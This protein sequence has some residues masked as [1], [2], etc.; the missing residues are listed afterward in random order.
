M[1]NNPFSNVNSI[2]IE[3]E[4]VS[5]G[6]VSGIDAVGSGI[7]ATVS[8]GKATFTVAAIGGTIDAE[9]DGVSVGSP[10]TLN[11]IGNGVKPPSMTGST[12][13][14]TFPRL[15]VKEI[16]VA[17]SFT[18]DA[19]LGQYNDI[20][21]ALT[22]ADAIVSGDATSYVIVK[23]LAGLHPVTSV[24]N[25]NHQVVLQFETGA[26]LNLSGFSGSTLIS[27][28][29]TNFIRNL[30]VG[31]AVGVG[32]PGAGFHW[33]DVEDT[34][35]A[36]LPATFI[37]NC[38]LWDG[39][40]GTQIGIDVKHG[41]TNKVTCFV[42]GGVWTLTSTA[43]LVKATGN[44]EIY[45]NK[46]AELLCNGSPCLDTNDSGASGPGVSVTNAV[47]NR[48]DAGDIITKSTNASVVG[49]GFYNAILDISKCAYRRVD[50]LDRMINAGQIYQEELV[51]GSPTD[52]DDY[53]IEAA[54]SILA[55][56]QDRHNSGGADAL[57]L[58]DLASPDDNT[59]L[60]VSTSAHG[61]TPKAPNDTDKFL[62]GDA[63][64]AVPLLGVTINA[65]TGTT[66]SL[67]NSDKG[68]LV[69]L[70]NASAIT[71]TVP[72]GLDSDFSCVIMQKG[73]GQVTISASGTTV[74]NADSFTK[75][76]KQYCY[77][78]VTHLGSNVYVTDGRLV[79]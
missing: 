64:W 63:T 69:T 2:E 32:A 59:D 48:V 76:E 9:D 36:Q 40:G 68:K 71:L 6:S 18:D 67:A 7:T 29:G 30:V 3:D 60:D 73:A 43:A 58:D 61:L 66:Y 47:L 19:D 16:K 49:S 56:H 54:L 25:L 65:Q 22:R 8:G 72:S 23:V 39:A 42:R 41:A 4:G 15:S 12:L 38:W 14:L 27:A 10:D 37:E 46:S 70:D 77:A 11:Y 44:S 34:G 53:S 31:N 79:P 50:G 57:K 1:I 13:D 5:Q 33:I 62:R 17:P 24:L 28:K 26:V 75:I 52:P 45:I 35:T 20:N 55:A 21:T 78:S 74:N 51:P